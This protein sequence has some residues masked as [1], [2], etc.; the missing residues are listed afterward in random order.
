MVFSGRKKVASYGKI[1]YKYYKYFKEYN[2]NSGSCHGIQ[3][4]LDLKT[5]YRTCWLFIYEGECMQADNRF[6]R[7]LTVLIHLI[8]GVCVAFWGCAVWFLFTDYEDDEYEV[9]VMMGIII[10]IIG[11]VFLLST[12]MC[13]IKKMKD[14]GRYAHEASVSVLVST[15]VTLIVICF[16]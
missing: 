5:R 9:G 16:C 15:A 10:L 11:L 3:E 13:L 6:K 2:T 7:L 8:I 4:T 1:C 12:E 14:K